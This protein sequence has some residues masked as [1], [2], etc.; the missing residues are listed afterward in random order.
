L[1]AAYV[2]EPALSLLTPQ[3]TALDLHEREH[4]ARCATEL[5]D[6]ITGAEPGP[7]AASRTLRPTLVARASTRGG[8]RHA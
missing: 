5:I 4:G 6:A 3:V 2:D 8:R 7:G 1:L